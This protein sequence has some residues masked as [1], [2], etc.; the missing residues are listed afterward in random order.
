MGS[1]VCVI[2]KEVQ[3]FPEEPGTV[4]VRGMAAKAAAT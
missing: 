4:L 3:P 2:E 1:L